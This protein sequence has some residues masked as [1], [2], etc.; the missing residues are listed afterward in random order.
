LPDPHAPK[1]YL[2]GY[3]VE[4][5]GAPAAFEP[6]WVGNDREHIYLIFPP[7]MLAEKAPMVREVTAQGPALV[8]SRQPA[9]KPVIVVDGLSERIEL[10]YGEGEH[11]QLIH[12]TRGQLEVITCP[13]SERCP[14]WP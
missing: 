11:A 13:A 9:G 1:R 14:R 4:S 7:T 6:V 2:V 8:N 5:K 3:T 10:R 12:I